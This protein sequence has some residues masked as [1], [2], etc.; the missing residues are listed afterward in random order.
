MAETDERLYTHSDAGDAFMTAVNA[1]YIPLEL[2]PGRKSGK[3]RC[4]KVDP[5][6]LNNTRFVRCYRREKRRK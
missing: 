6:E 3:W 2:F 1:G 5:S 4:I